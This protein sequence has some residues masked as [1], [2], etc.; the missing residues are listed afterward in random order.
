ML[1]ALICMLLMY[2]RLKESWKNSQ[3][4]E[5]TQKLWSS[6]YL[7][8]REKNKESPWAARWAS[9]RSYS[10]PR[11]SRGRSLWKE[12]WYLLHCVFYPGDQ[13]SPASP[14][15]KKKKKLKSWLYTS[16]STLIL[17]VKKSYLQIL[18]V[19]MWRRLAHWLIYRTCNNS[20]ITQL[21]WGSTEKTFGKS[22]SF[23]NCKVQSKC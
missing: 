10:H 11:P 4:V 3:S 21:I 14:A 23:V 7:W 13:A 12:C 2:K 6:K 18:P 20:Y 8:P 17:G 16:N 9:Q 15:K 5:D 22:H 19:K 1:W